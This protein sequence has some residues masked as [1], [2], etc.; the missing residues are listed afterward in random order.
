MKYSR[1]LII[2]AFV[3]LFRAAPGDCQSAN[4]ITFTM[5]QDGEATIAINDSTGA[6][7]RNLFGDVHF[8]KGEH[9]VEW[10]GCDDEGKPVAAGDYR[11]V[12]LYRGDL[13]VVYRGSFQYGTPPWLYDG[14][15][16]WTADHSSAT[17]VAAVGDRVLLGSAEAEWGHGLISTDLDGHK[18]WGVRWLEKR[19]WCGAEALATVGDRMFASSA[20]DQNAVWE[21]DPATGKNSLVLEKSDLPPD[22]LNTLPLSP[23]PYAPG[24][25]VIG[26]HK[27]EGDPS[28]ELYVV[29]VFGKE[30]RTYVFSPGAAGEK[31]KLLRVLAVRP[32]GLAWLPD[33]RCVATMDHTVDVLNT[34][35]GE[36]TPLVNEGLSSPFGIATDAKGRIYV[37]DQGDT[38][39]HHFTPEAILLIRGL[40]LKGESSQQV[41]VFDST[42]HLLRAIGQKGGQQP[43]KIDPESF[44]QPAGIAV[45]SRGRLWVTQYTISPKRVSVF[46]IPDDLGPSS[47]P[48]LAKQFL[49]PAMYG[50]GA[51]MVDPEEPWR[52]MD[53]NTGAI[54]D[55][56][57]ADKKYDAVDLPW[58]PY[59]SWKEH[60]YRPELPFL[61][62]PGVVFNL[63]GRKFTA[64]QGGYGNGPQSHWEPERFDATGPVMIGEYK[65]DVFVPE[66]AIGNLRMWMRD[67]E[68]NTR[69]EEQWMPPVILEAARKLP[70]WPKYAAQMGI[71][72]DATD[73]PHRAHPRGTSIWIANPWPKEISGFIWVDANGDG[74]MQA[75]EI[76]FHDMPDAEQVTLDHQLN[77]YIPADKARGGGVY[78]FKREGFNKIGAPVYTWANVAKISDDDFHIDQVGDDGSMLSFGALHSAQGKLVWSYPIATKG[79][80]DLGADKRQTLQ[81]GRIFR[82]N[83]MPG[84]V[85]GPGDLGPVYMLHSVD[86]MSYL[87]TR[88]DGLFISTIFRPYAFADSWDTIPEA[89]P[90]MELDKYTLGEEC[91]SGH[92]ARAGASGE[93]FEK[94]HYYLLGL[95]RSAVTE[96]TGLETVKRFDGGTVQLVQGAG[97]YGKGGHL[98][99]GAAAGAIPLNAQP[100]PGAL[101]AA[102]VMP[103]VEAF[104]E[105]PAQFATATLWT[106]WDKRGL[107]VKCDVHGDDS[108]FINNDTDWTMAF[109]TGDVVDLQLKSQKLGRCRYVITMNQGKP[110]VVRLRY[111]G[112][113]T[114]RAVTY[115]S[116]VAETMVPDVEKLA[117]PVDVRR[118]KNSYNLQVTLPWDV[119]GIE[120]KPGLEIPMELGLF[121]SDPTGHKTVSREYWHSGV[122][123]MVSDVPTEARPTDDWGVL[124][125][126]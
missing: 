75:D 6:R 50:G 62:T 8:T 38:G 61:G 27:A 103:G 35:T 91:W 124:K 37:S 76:Q 72:P 116:G 117:V 18:Q 7:V 96:L 13:H 125:L 40:R 23:L 48:K 28:G 110:V 113:V 68:T 12:G 94:D 84:V 36:T 49:G 5:P 3:T 53:T 10:D 98:N 70:D 108:P 114:T 71:A 107:H 67:R 93:G 82:V 100:K 24:L 54:F 46:D 78:R 95:G 19:A 55:V 39:Q 121:Y 87:L 88:D 123:G 4:T 14:I 118:G 122:S 9:A 97:L 57:I 77:A 101:V 33:G 112:P 126:Q 11:W 92:F 52:I 99:P 25:R 51:A 43:G 80:R 111:D 73:V 31:L 74:K 65:G 21:V 79:I 59:D 15:G 69:R 104:R 90:G 17:A 120:P 41:K 26:G 34:T 86:G 1:L 58:R 20:Q 47:A 45:D 44:W 2:A 30:P 85:K 56:N 32:W 115:K 102:T 29:D 89:K 60:A 83:V 42:G 119:L 22:K 105:K 16:G 81:P 63:E 109:T 106:A 64:M 66:A